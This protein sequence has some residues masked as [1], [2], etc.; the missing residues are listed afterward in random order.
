MNGQDMNQNMDLSGLAKLFQQQTE[1]QKLDQIARQEAQAKANLGSSAIQA[2]GQLVGGLLAQRAQEQMQ[3][4]QIEAQA[5]QQQTASEAE[6]LV[7][8]Q[9]QQQDALGRLMASYRSALI[10]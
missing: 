3:A 9:Q 4:R 1:Q 7:K 5:A 6:S 2:T 8:A 10:K